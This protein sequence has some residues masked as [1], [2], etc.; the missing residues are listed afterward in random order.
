VDLPHL[1]C[2][3]SEASPCGD[4]LEYDPQLLELQRAAEGQPERRMGDAVLAAEPPDWRKTREIAGALFARGKDLRIAN[5]LVRSALALDG[6]PGLAE[7]LALVRELLGRYWDDLYPRLDH[8]DHDDPTLRLN[9]LAELAGEPVLRLL[10]DAPLLHSRA[11]GPLS[12]R[13]ALQ[14]AG[15][16]PGSAEGLGREQ[17]AGALQDSDP[18]R[19]AGDRAALEEARA[20]LAAIEAEVAGHVGAARSLDLG[21]LARLLRQA[22]QLLAEPPPHGAGAAA[23]DDDETGRPAA[24]DAPSA[25][26]RPS[27]GGV[28]IASRDDVLHSLDRLLGYYRQHEPS[29]P[30]PVLL[31]R[32]KSLVNADFAEIVR[33]LIPDGLA[34]FEKLQGPGGD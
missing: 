31:A 24:A 30:V 17:L 6:L 9:T 26:E 25:S 16:S 34:Q 27:R 21:A 23:E 8:E 32:A 3:I 1:L 7:G 19:L 13:A 4:D 15:L 18:Q 29:S 2:A 28:P 10:R 14:A 5:Y 11:F 12:L 20:S 22:G 33:N